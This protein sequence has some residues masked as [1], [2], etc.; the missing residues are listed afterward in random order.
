MPRRGSRV[1]IARGVYQDHAGIAAVVQVGSGDTAQRE[2]MRFP[3]D[4]ETETIRKW[5]RRTRQRLD[6]TATK[7]PGRGS[8]SADIDRYLATTTGRRK[9][10]AT[11]LLEPWRAALGDKP[12]RWITAV[13][14]KTVLADWQHPPADQRRYSAS[15]LNHRLSTLRALYREL[16]GEDD[17]APNPTLR[18]TKLQEPKPQPREIPRAFAEALLD[19]LPKRGRPV[20][21]EKRSK[22]SL[23]A[24]RLR[25]LATTPLPPKQLMGLRPEHIDWKA[26]A[27]WVTPRRKGEGTEGAWLPLSPAAVKALR[28]FFAA[29]ATGAY[30][31]SAAAQV[32]HRAVTRTIAA[33]KAD[34]RTLPALP[35]KLRPYDL[36]H[37]FLTEAY[38]RSKDLSA[39]QELGQ[40]ADPRTTK[41]YMV[42][43]VSEGAKAAVEKMAEADRAWHKSRG[44]RRKA[45]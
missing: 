13:M 15:Y 9:V 19:G 1:R 10:E 6:G 28:A 39:T 40:H 5:Q 17:D 31:T 14:L 44:T 4:T 25:V 32:W 11:I 18:I 43:A 8:L 26:R 33:Y 21:K 3:L 42:A 7:R 12:R 45:V 37:S 29:G 38:R 16:D 35:P 24:A 36:R 22:V 30:S 2:E 23:T 41:R 34:K 20:R 27:V